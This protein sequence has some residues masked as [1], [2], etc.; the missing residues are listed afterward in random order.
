MEFPIRL[1]IVVKNK[2]CQ[3]GSALPLKELTGRT[4]AADCALGN[5][6]GHVR[7]VKARMMLNR[8]DNGEDGKTDNTQR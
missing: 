7:P 6:I 8:R 4:E 1:I 2:N 3:A 5:K